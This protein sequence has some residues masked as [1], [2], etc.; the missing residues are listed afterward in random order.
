M[1]VRYIKY[2][3]FIAKLEILFKRLVFDS[4]CRNNRK[5]SR[6]SKEGVGGERA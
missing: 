2:L 1:T 5:I 3:I 4:L 6:Y